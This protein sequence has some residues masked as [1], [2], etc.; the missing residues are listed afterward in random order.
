MPVESHVK[1]IWTVDRVERSHA[2]ATARPGAPQR[3]FSLFV[4][5]LQMPVQMPVR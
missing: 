1:R 3:R 5:V 2:N 4:Q